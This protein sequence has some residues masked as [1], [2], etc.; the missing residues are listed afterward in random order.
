MLL[1]VAAFDP[2]SALAAAR[3]GAGRIELCR[4]AEVG[5]LTPPLDW[6]RAVT[7]AVDL[8]VMVMVRPHA[9]GWT[10]SADEHAAMRESARLGVEAGAAGV[11][12]G[13]LRADGTI[14]GPALRALVEAVAPHPVTVHRAFDAARDLGEA[15]DAIL[16]A[17][18][19]R[20]LTG[21]GPGAARTN[22][23]RLA[24]LVRRAGDG[25]TVMPGGGVR[26]RHVAELVRRTGAR[27]VHSGA[28]APGSSR[29]DP[30]EVRRLRAALDALG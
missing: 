26:A 7:E 8:P 6:V 12:W 14:D 11:V 16:D 9:D 24:A 19:A 27:E 30:D 21:G 22:A 15:L 4:A 23:D 17:G 5:G 1:E 20:V 25:L 10:F 13:A 29:V 3:A 18:A 28:S 2:A